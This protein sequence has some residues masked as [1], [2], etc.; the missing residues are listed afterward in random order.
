MATMSTD[1]L[2]MRMRPIIGAISTSMRPSPADAKGR[3]LP[4]PLP[5]VTIARQAGAG[6]VTLAQVL[7]KHL[8][9]P[10]PPK[11]PWGAF[12]RELVERVAA[13]HQISASLIDSLGE[14]SSSWLSEFFAGLRFSDKGQLANELQVFRRVAQTIRALAQVGRV[15]IVG[16]G[17]AYITRNMPGGVHVRLVAPLEHRIKASAERH[18]LSQAE[19]ADHIRQFDQNRQ[20]FYKRYW[21]D[22]TQGPELFT[23]TLNTSDLDEDQLIECITP[24]IRPPVRAADASS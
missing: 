15:V 9:E 7:V 4:A 22:Q 5:F 3:R 14:A 21:P 24:M 11:Q 20:A 1:N 10:D 23:A 12:D 16:R 8:N 13:D 6:G 18:Q 2:Q 19:A 17:G